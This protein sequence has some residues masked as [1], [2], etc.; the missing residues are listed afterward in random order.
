MKTVQREPRSRGSLAS[1]AL[2]A[3]SSTFICRDS[4]KDSRKEPQPDEQA[5]FSMMLSMAPFLI[6]R[7]FISWPPMSI[8][9]STSGRKWRA[10][11]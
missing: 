11:L 6:R 8:I 10:A 3:N 4:A 2:A 1:R 9:R 5:S 7:H